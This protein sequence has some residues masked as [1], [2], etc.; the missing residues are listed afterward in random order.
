MA[1]HEPLFD[2]VCCECQQPFK[3][4]AHHRICPSCVQSYIDSQMFDDEDCGQ[5]DG[6][7]YTYDC[8]DGCC[9]NAEEGCRLCER[10]CDFCNPFKPTPKQA[11][12][13]AQLGK[14]LTGALEQ[15]SETKPK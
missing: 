9:A 11:E 13:R 6:S 3:A 7:G 2:L 12:E 15:S 5:C 14:I 10:R 4:E 1:D 8:I